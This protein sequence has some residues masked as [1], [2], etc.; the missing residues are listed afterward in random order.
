MLV[1]SQVHKVQI[2][3]PWGIE[4]AVKFMD[5]H[6]VPTQQFSTL[7]DAIKACRRDLDAGMFSIVVKDKANQ[8]ALLCCPLPPELAKVTK[9]AVEQHGD[10]RRRLPK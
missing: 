5:Q 4:S 9:S 10:V 8:Q 3:T 2:Q 6:F 7:E 1:I